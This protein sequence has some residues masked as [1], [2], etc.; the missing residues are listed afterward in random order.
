MLQSI[1]NLQDGDSYNRRLCEVFTILADVMAAAGTRHKRRKIQHTPWS[2]ANLS[3]SSTPLGHIHYIS[4]PLGALYNNNENH[5]ASVQGGSQDIVNL[6]A[7]SFESLM[8]P[9]DSRS[10]PEDGLTAIMGSLERGPFDSFD[11]LGYSGSQAPRGESLMEKE[12]W[13]D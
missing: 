2:S 9:A 1:T 6:P 12:A 4:P 13:W 10:C 5:I 7:S 8:S 3:S 11:L